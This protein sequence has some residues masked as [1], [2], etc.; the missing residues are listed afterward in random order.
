LENIKTR[1]KNYSYNIKEFKNFELTFYENIL[2]FNEE[3]DIAEIKKKYDEI[4][5]D[6]KNLL[7]N[8]KFNYKDINIQEELNILDNKIKLLKNRLVVYEAILTKYEVFAKINYNNSKNYNSA[9]VRFQN[10]MD[11]IKINSVNFEQLV[12]FKTKLYED[13]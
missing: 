9:I 6:E 11:K 12:E 13:Y 3:I 8:L 4:D 2:K 7:K 1:L 10:I 5:L